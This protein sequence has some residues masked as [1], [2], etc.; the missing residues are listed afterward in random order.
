MSER[1]DKREVI[2]GI[3]DQ[4][5]KEADK[6]LSDAESM[7][8]VRRQT[9]ES[10]ADRIVSEAEERAEKE[11]DRLTKKTDA[12]ISAENRRA[13]LSLEQQIYRRIIDVVRAR[14]HEL[15]GDDL[16][17]EVLTGWIAE[18][19]IG[20]GATEATV[21]VSARETDAAERVVEDAAETA[22]TAL[23]FTCSLSIDDSNPAPRQGVIATS[24]DGETAYNNQ[25]ETRIAR[26]ETQIRSIVT[27][28]VLEAET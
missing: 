19:A 8:K 10:R 2:E 17:D 20:L 24:A 3:L 18:A 15:V 14:F 16:Y 21:R 26:Y 12:A 22:S 7:T 28:E 23:G 4:A 9:L 6:I 1:P 11:S 13:S 27:S 5:R 25:L